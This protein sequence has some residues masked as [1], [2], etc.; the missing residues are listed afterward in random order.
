MLYVKHEIGHPE[1][2]FADGDFSVARFNAPQG[3][4]FYDENTLFV[5]DTENHAI[6]KVNFLKVLIL[7]SIY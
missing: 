4:V 2:G 7:L 1:V 6:R 5:A 3:L